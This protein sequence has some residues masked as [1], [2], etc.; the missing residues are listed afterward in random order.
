EAGR[1]GRGAAA[2]GPGE[3]GQDEG[4]QPE[5][6]RVARRHAGAAGAAALRLGVRLDA[7]ARAAP[8]GA[9]AVLGGTAVV[10]GVAPADAAAGRHVADAAASA[11]RI[12]EALH[13]APPVADGARS[14][15]GR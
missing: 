7:P 8:G 1:S 15:G 12:G 9:G 3:P 10:A 2:A 5:D 11:L 6:H 14:A 13:A 4:A